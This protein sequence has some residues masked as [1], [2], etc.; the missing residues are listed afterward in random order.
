MRLTGLL[1]QFHHSLVVTILFAMSPNA[2]AMAQM[3]PDDVGGCFVAYGALGNIE[4]AISSPNLEWACGGGPL[5]DVIA[6]FGVKACS[7]G[8]IY[9]KLKKMISPGSFLNTNKLS[10]SLP[11]YLSHHSSKCKSKSNQSSSPWLPSSLPQTRR[12]LPVIPIKHF[13]TLIVIVGAR[14][15]RA[16]GGGVVR[17]VKVRPTLSELY[18]ALTLSQGQVNGL[19]IGGATRRSVR[20]FGPR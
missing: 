19:Y 10:S 1:Y 5:W 15:Q 13:A 16:T 8:L 3:A 12:L 7:I 2:L 17:A 20:Q 11:S 9:F 18:H 14:G 4:S 6:L